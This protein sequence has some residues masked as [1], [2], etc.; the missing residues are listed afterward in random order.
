MIAVF[1]DD[2][3]MIRAKQ[4]KGYGPLPSVFFA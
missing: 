1:S 3:V 4:S 2:Q